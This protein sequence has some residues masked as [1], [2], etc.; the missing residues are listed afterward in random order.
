MSSEGIIHK[1][2]NIVKT[3]FTQYFDLIFEK[4]YE[5]RIFEYLFKKYVSVRYFNMRE[6]TNYE[7]TLKDAI[8]AEL[9]L[10]SE[11]LIQKYT[12][13]KV[14]NIKNILI[15][16]AGF[17]KITK[18]KKTESIIQKIVDFRKEKLDLKKT[19]FTRLFKETLDE[20]IAIKRNFINKYKSDDF[21]LK[22]TLLEKDKKIYKAEVKYN[23][24]FSKL[25]SKSIIKQT[26]ESGLTNEDRLFV[27]YNL[28]AVKVLEDIIKEDFETAYMLDFTT[29]LLSKKAKLTRLLKIIGD[30]YLKEKLVLSI[31]YNDFEEGNKDELYKIMRQGYKFAVVLDKELKLAEKDISRLE[32]FSYILINEKA[33]LYKHV[34][35]TKDIVDNIIKI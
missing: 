29:T 2:V 34:S 35:K 14:E 17:D 20:Q 27:E 23:I 21:D 7:L 8:K 12:E 4:N 24:Q 9:D 16:L 26:F 30:D 18:N 22:M 11:R 33:E 15:Y 32:I 3:E 19:T 10:E 28:A 1:Y 25:Y 6:E 13:E 5:K 31:N